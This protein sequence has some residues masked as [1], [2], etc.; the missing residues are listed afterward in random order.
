[1]LGETRDYLHEAGQDVE[2]PNIVLPLRGRFKGETGNN[3][4]FVITI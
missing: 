3:F 4:Y 1:M 2:L